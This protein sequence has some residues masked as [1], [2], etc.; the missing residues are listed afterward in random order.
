M[1]KRN[2]IKRGICCWCP[3]QVPVLYKLLLCQQC[4]QPCVWLW[5]CRV[6]FAL[7]CRLHQF[8]QR[9]QQHLQGSREFLHIP[10]IFQDNP[11]GFRSWFLS[12]NKVYITAILSSSNETLV[13]K[14]SST[15][16]FLIGAA[17]HSVHVY[18]R[19]P[20]SCSA[21]SMSKQLPTF[22]CSCHP[23]HLSGSTDRLHH[24]QSPVHDGSKVRMIMYIILKELL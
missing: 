9:P 24:S 20:E 12:P 14:V 5:C 6:Y 2:W 18:T 3:L 15:C 19:E 17:I 13:V 21:R 23:C 22:P 11:A 10:A 4:F 1:C 8:H 16:N 7:S